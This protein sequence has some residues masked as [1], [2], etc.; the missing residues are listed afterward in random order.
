MLHRIGFLLLLLSSACLIPAH[1][2]HLVTDIAVSGSPSG[3]AVNPNNNRI[4]VSLGTATGYAVAVIDG[5]TNTVI[6]TVTVSHAF[7]ITANPVNGRFTPRDA[8]LA[9]APSPAVSP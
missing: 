5:S 4:Y 1:A 9:R 7:V 6:D 3:V 2:Q 8:T